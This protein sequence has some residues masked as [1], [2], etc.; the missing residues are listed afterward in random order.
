[1]S[2]DARLL[3]ET[4]PGQTRALL[5]DA[6]HVVEAWHDFLHDPDLP[7]SVH[8]VRIDR[9]FAAQN[10]ATARL[11]DGTAMSIRTS[12]HDRLVAGDLA[13]VTITA[14]RREGKPWQAVPGARLVGR[15]VILLPSE[16]GIASSS[17]MPEP[18]PAD[19]MA[20]LTE[21]LGATPGFGVI[22]RRDAGVAHDLP[23]QLS[24]LI[25]DWTG[26]VTDTPG[27]GCLY[28]GEGLRG[29]LSRSCP[30]LPVDVVVPET[31]AGFAADWDAMIEA[32]QSD[33]V[34]LAG[35]G[36]LWIE[37]TRALTAIDLDSGRGDLAGLMTEAPA[38]IAA[39]LRLRQTGGLV[40]VDV[41]RASKPA[42]ARFD[43]ALDAAL[44]GDPRHPERIGRTRGGLIELRFPHGRCG[45]DAWAAD[46]VVTGALSVLREVAL[47]PALAVARVELPAVMADW[48]RGPGASAL[49]ALD[50][51]VE[52]VVSSDA[53]AATLI[54]A[55]R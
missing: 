21:M 25:A 55:P 30:G 17:R 15:H 12:R 40:A 34:T 42:G 7:G 52:L 16:A 44:A 14:A 22:L 47:R 51:P 19:V 32:C 37:T 43:A 38:A 28:G 1:M 48:L 24:A 29:R 4:A 11:A 33:E 3:I 54:E 26:G 50:R 35:G 5:Y 46:P 8:K 13:I 36:R 53:T 9:V 23:A 18:L 31:A 49:A 10:R 2:G 39:Q 41:P 20:Q 6:G 45:P 27:E